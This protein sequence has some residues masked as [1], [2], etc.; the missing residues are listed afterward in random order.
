MSTE[1]SIYQEIRAKSRRQAKV[2]QELDAEA[3]QVKAVW[4]SHSP[5]RTG[6]YAASITVVDRPD[7]DGFPAKRIIARAWY[8]HLIEFGTGPDK[9]GS[10]SRFGPNT[11]TPAFAPRA[12]TAAEFGGDES[13]VDV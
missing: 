9:P 12:K 11:P 4:V 5:V 6:N 3:E 8:A 10:H 1:E 7:I 2:R 13:S